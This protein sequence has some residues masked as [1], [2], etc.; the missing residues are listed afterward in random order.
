M[1]NDMAARVL[2][3]EASEVYFRDTIGS[4]NEPSKQQLAIW[5]NTG[6]ANGGKQREFFGI[7]NLELEGLVNDYNDIVQKEIK[8]LRFA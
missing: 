4:E 8:E 6:T 5:H 1:M 7:S 2:N 3:N